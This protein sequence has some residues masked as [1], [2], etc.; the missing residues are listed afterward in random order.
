[1]NRNRHS[2]GAHDLTLTGIRFNEQGE[3]VAIDVTRKLDSELIEPDKAGR[4]SGV[5]DSGVDIADC[6]LHI[7]G[8]AVRR[9]AISV[10]GAAQA[11]TI[12]DQEQPATSTYAP[13]RGAPCSVR[14]R[15]RRVT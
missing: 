7:F 3:I 4:R 1:M 6:D 15:V 10:V 12:K 14:M 11:G 8:H 9:I 5:N 2:I 13:T